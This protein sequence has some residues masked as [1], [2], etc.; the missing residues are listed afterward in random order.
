MVSGAADGLGR[1]IARVEIDQ[2]VPEAVASSGRDAQVR[3]QTFPEPEISRCPEEHE[4]AQRKRNYFALIAVMVSIVAVGLA[5][6]PIAS[7]AGT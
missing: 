6:Q 4:D 2:Y 5:G 3:R 1:L 7:N